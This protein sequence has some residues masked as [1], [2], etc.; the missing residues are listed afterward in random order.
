ML[1]PVAKSRTI[2]MVVMTAPTSTTNITGFFI[3][4]RGFSLR[5]ESPMARFTIGGSSSGRARAPFLGTIE[6]TS[7][8]DD[9]VGTIVVAIILAPK[10]PLNHQKMLDDRAE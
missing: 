3:M 6:V 1:A 2:R 8:F 4:M 5:K 10:L 7:L 9:G